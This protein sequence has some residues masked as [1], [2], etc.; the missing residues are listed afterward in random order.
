MLTRFF[1][2]MAVVTLL[3][4]AWALA[5]D[6][7]AATDLRAMFPATTSAPTGPLDAGSVELPCYE[8][9][10]G[11]V[12]DGDLEKWRG[13]PP[14]VSAHWFKH[15]E[16]NALIT[17]SDEF[18][19]AFY[20]GRVKD[21]DDLMVL[22]VIQDRCVFGYESAQW[23]FGDNVEIFVDLLRQARLEADPGIT[24]QPSRYQNAD[25]TKPY[26]DPAAYAQIGLLP[27]TPLGPGKMLH[28]RTYGRSSSLNWNITYASTPVSGGVAYE[29]KIDGQAACKAVG[30]DALPAIVSIEPVIGAVDYPLL[31]EA[32]G[33]KNHRGYFRTFGDYT[34]LAYPLRN[35]AVNTTPLPPQGDKLPAETL[36]SKFGNTVEKIQPVL[37]KYLVSFG[38]PLRE[39]MHVEWGGELFYWAACNGILFDKNHLERFLLRVKEKPTWNPFSPGEKVALRA[40]ELLAQAML[41]PL[42]DADARN[43]VAAAIVA[44]PQLNTPSA[45][46]AACLIAA[47]LKV[48]DPDDL[49]ALLSHEDMTVAVAAGRALV[50]VGKAEH[51]AAFRKLYDEKFT[52]LSA[53]KKPDDRALLAA[54]RVFVQPSLELLEFRVDPPAPPATVLRREILNANTDLPRLMPDDNNHV[55]NGQLARAWPAE[56]PR[57]LWRASLG[58]EGVTAT[59]VE[60]D[61]KTF[62]MGGEPVETPTADGKGVNAVYTQ[63]AYCFNASDGTELWKVPV[64]KGKPTYG[65]ASSPIVDGGRVY[66]FPMGAAACLNTADGSDVWRSDAFRTPTFPSPILIGDVL[67]IPGKSLWAVNKMTGELL[68]TSPADPAD[69]ADR[70]DHSL[71]SPAYTEID[72][73][74]V[75][76]TGF[77]NGP[78]AEI[79]GLNPADGELFFRK[80]ITS[81]W[82]LCSSPVIDGSRLYVCSGQAGQEFFACFQLFVRDG[83]VLAMPVF[84]RPDRQS[85]YSATLAVWDGAVYGF[86][87]AGL[88]CCDAATGDLLWSEK[89]LG[90]LETVSHLLLA[91]GLLLIR[92]GQTLV[93]A[94]ANKSAYRERGRFDAPIKLTVQQHTLANGRL[95]LRGEDTLIVYEVGVKPE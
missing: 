32:G 95:Y 80:A 75:L 6:G 3:A 36:A 26:N 93:L 56:G 57:E 30:L 86:G 39:Q 28:S 88:E 73:V 16:S 5:Q 46:V 53:S 85:N 2:A 92:S 78:N 22:V 21:T 19:P 94:E 84:S 25:S 55:Y 12:A 45:L 13:V 47:E 44:D 63:F 11:S 15:N 31:L 43:T 74:P 60:A 50:A 89:S 17:P 1:L 90:G 54:F 20:L 37:A 71:A 4:T 79:V 72:S 18:S 82:G 67:Y 27:R 8:L 59:A 58:G 34:T 48:G 64:G 29:V 9:P 35:G 83:K 52:A 24:T 49:L 10:A 69:P 81:S 77:G 33:W 40:K 38:S 42:Q 91:D 41:N 62:V 65:T 66:F 61:G 51:A 7:P 87:N 70:R 14:A 76:I 68:W 23:T